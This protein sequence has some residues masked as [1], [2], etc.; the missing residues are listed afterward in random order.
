[1]IQRQE[2]AEEEAAAPESGEESEEE[3]ERLEASN[4]APIAQTKADPASSAAGEG[5]PAAL[6]TVTSRQNGGAPLDSVT[7]NFMESRFGHDF[8]RVRVHTDSLA[9]DA[10]R[11]VQARAFTVGQNIWFA[12][13]QFSPGS[14]AGRQL[15]AHELTHTVQQGGLQGSLVSRAL[16]RSYCPSSCATLEGCGT[17][18]APKVKRDNCAERDEVDPNNKI[19]HIRVTLSD[20][21]VTLFWNGTPRTTGGTQE[22]PFDCTPNETDTPKGW[23]TVGVKCGVN[24]TSYERYNMAWFAGFKSHGYRFGFHDSQPVDAACHSHGCVRVSCENAEKINKN[25]KSN[26]TSIIVR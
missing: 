7:R 5:G 25:S 1:L 13:G 15:L 10:A 6:D 12:R 20:R 21:K 11:S 22:A 9:H 16:Q 17:C 26:W 3:L 4:V 18:R 19:S 23:D 14:Q 8:S 24:H 2:E